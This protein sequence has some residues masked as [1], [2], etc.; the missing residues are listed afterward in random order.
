[1]YCVDQLKQTENEFMV[2]IGAQQ[3]MGPMKFEGW[4]ANGWL[5]SKHGRSALHPSSDGTFPGEGAAVMLL[6]KVRHGQTPIAKPLAF[7]RGIGTSMDS[8]GDVSFSRSA[9]RANQEAERRDQPANVR[10]SPMGVPAIDEPCRKGVCESLGTI[11]GES[12]KPIFKTAND[13]FGHLTGGSGMVECL[14]SIAH[15]AL[16]DSK[17]VGPMTRNMV[18]IG[19]PWECIYSVI[20]DVLKEKND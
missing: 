5:G 17:A 11:L 6:Q 19:S 4:S 9:T 14:A 7:V 15:A 1:M 8:M 13:S 3:D 18:Q 12:D 2:C 16:E 20:I 10:F